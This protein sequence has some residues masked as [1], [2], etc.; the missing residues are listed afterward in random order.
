MTSDS[1]T[2]KILL[3]AD[4]HLGFDQPLRPR[5]AR[6]RRGP[7]FFE[8]Y[9]RCLVPALTG[10][11][12]LVVHGGDLFFRS[13]VSSRVIHDAFQPLIRIADQGVPVFLVPGNHERSNIPVTLL[14]THRNIHI[15]SQPKTFT[16][17][18]KGR[19]IALS[20]FPFYRGSIR[21]HFDTLLD[22]TE[23]SKQEADIRALCL[24]QS[25]EGAQVGVQN[26]TFR[27]APDVISGHQIPDGFAAVLAG[28]IHRQ[29][30]LMTDLAGVTLN[31]PVFYPGSIERTSFAERN[32]RKGYLVIDIGC[33]ASD[34]RWNFFEL[35]TRPMA[36]IAIERSGL[37]ADQ[38]TGWLRDTLN[39]LD[40]NSVVQIRLPEDFPD[41]LLKRLSAPFLRSIAPATMNISL[42][43]FQR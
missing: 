15:F 7:D 11:V 14:E 29:Q 40:P 41:H 20:G 25:V 36:V 35:P 33:G 26:Y 27:P 31:A 9:Q 2:I 8:N 32:E 22:Q 13:R 12:D 34:V 37:S 21:E 42:S 39:R 17:E 24:H 5:V 6:R 30:V 28:H 43:L 4:T 38:L 19:R 1:T 16:R 18:V 10:D 3:L 23:F